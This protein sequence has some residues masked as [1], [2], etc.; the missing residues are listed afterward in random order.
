MAD[1]P[2]PTTPEEYIERLESPR[3]E[4]LR[5]LHDLIREAVPDWEPHIQSG[6]IG[7]G[8]Y[9]YRYD[10]G[11]QGDWF[12]VGL[13]SNKRYIS[14]YVQCTVEGRYLAETYADRLPKASV[15]KSCVRFK[16]V[17]G[18]DQETLRALL[19]DAGTHSPAGA[20]S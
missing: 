9:H 12:H 19:V 11:R 13:A 18:V 5:R 7:Y 20:V 17:A 10:S 1:P 14:L 8:R 4:Q 16:R 6:M 15:G 3:R 2:A